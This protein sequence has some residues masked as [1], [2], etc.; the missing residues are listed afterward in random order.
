MI[1]TAW[2]PR[3]T[4]WWSLVILATTLITRC[5]VLFTPM[6]DNDEAVYSAL[7]SRILNGGMP[8]VGAIDHKPPGIALTYAAIYRVTGSYQLLFVQIFLLVVVAGTGLLI[9]ALAE[10]IYRHRWARLAGVVYVVA[11][12]WGPARDVQAANTELFLNLPLVAAAFLTVRGVD[13]GRGSLLFAAGLLTGVAGLYKYQAVL[14]GG[15]WLLVVVLD[16][17]PH[18]L[19]RV[20]LL[21]AGFLTIAAAFLAFF[22]F[23]DNW[24]SFVFWGWSY[25][26]RYIGTLSLTQKLWNGTR[27][28]AALAVCWSPLLMSLRRPASKQLLM[29]GWLI[30]MGCAIA[31]GGR[32]FP[33]YFLMALPPVC[34]LVVPGLV[35]PHRRGLRLS[36]AAGLTIISL[37]WAWGW[38]DLWPGLRGEIDTYHR[39]AAYLREHSSPDDSLF[40]WGDSPELYL[41]SQRSMGTRFPS[42]NYHTGKIW[43]SPLIDAD[44]TDTESHIVAEA[45][46]ELL[47]DLECERPLFFVD[48]AAGGM[49]GFELHPLT[50]YPRLAELVARDYRRVAT[51]DGIPIY[52]STERHDPSV[53]T[54]RVTCPRADSRN[55]DDAN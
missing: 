31:I 15:A 27:A 43:G 11:S 25:N 14:A 24:D 19:R 47:E 46:P 48:A 22:Y 9:A 49:S 35:D 1:P 4:R 30:T 7:A 26:F 55:G 18:V 16:G 21:A 2:P 42:S 17:G 41:F 29:W 50:R 39:V 8:Y 20:A 10:H 34:L 45:W 53:L 40:V 54:A 5:C 37:V 32:F 23:S 13:R 44:A 38:Y 3:S 52:R 36:I 6:Y 12:T 28:A 51:I 33:H